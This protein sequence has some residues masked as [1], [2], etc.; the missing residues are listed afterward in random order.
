MDEHDQQRE[1]HGRKYEQRPS[2]KA[3]ALGLEVVAGRP[4]RAATGFGHPTAAGR[5]DEVLPVHR[6]T[7]SM[8]KQGSNNNKPGP[9]RA[10][11]A[12]ISG[13]R[14]QSPSLTAFGR[15]DLFRPFGT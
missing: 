13:P 2:R 15:G 1:K 8:L 6:R 4:A 5:A 10:H 11:L 7:S 3:H 9:N 12:P 14:H